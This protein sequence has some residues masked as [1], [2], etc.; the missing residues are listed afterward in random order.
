MRSIRTAAWAAFVV[1]ARVL[2]AQPGD[3]IVRGEVGARVDS[4]LTRA[5][6]HGLSGSIL[7]AKGGEVLL[8]KGYGLADRE[9]G[10]MIG[11]N[12]PFF[13]GSLAKQFTATAILRLEAAGKLDL[14]DSLGTFFKDVPPDKRGVTV[15]QLLSHTSGL[16]YLPNAGLFGSGTRDSVMHEMLAER[17]SFTPGS[18][19]EYSTPGYVLLAGVIERA[20]GLTYEK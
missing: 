3:V 9:R 18:R 16:P 4:F 19:Y 12:T 10:V 2:T 14:D 20:S 17:I 13:I 7:V 1:M 15:R 8:Q 6:M 5:A 11:P